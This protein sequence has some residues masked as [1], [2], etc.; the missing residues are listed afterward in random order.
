MPCLFWLCPGV[1]E[2]G[3]GARASGASEAGRPSYS[4]A[5]SDCASYRSSEGVP[6]SA[7]GESPYLRL[8]AMIQPQVGVG[9]RPWT[10]GTDVGFIGPLSTAAAALLKP[11]GGMCSAPSVCATMSCMHGS[12]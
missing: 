11:H 4:D 7:R 1:D 8:D 12:Y 6:S 9:E 10:Q 3:G 2:K 5:D